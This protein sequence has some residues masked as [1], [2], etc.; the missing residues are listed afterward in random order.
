MAD[1]TGMSEANELVFLPLGGTGEIGMNLNLYGFGPPDARK[2]MMVDLGVTF[3]D[4]RTPGIDVIMADPAFIEERREDLLGIVLTHGHEDH[5]GAVAHLWPSLRCD[6]YATPFT[7]ELVKAKLIEAG[8]EQEVPLKIVELGSR[9]TLG[10]FDIELVTLTHSIPEPNALAI[11]TPLGLVMHTGDWKIDP[12]PVVGG[13][14]DIKR[15]TELGQ[16]GVRAMVCD[17]TN[18]FSPGE[19]GSEADVAKGLTELIKDMKGRVAVTT[20][21][22]NVA[23]LESVIRAAEACGRHVVLAG[24]AMHRVTTAARKT[25][26]LQNLPPIVPEDEAGYLPPENVLYL[27]TGSQGEPRAALARIAMDNHPHVTLSEGDTVIFS[28]RMIPGNDVEIYELQ[29]LLAERGIRVIT[30][31]DHFVH[32]SGHPC[33][34]ELARMYQWIKPEVAVPVHGEA[35]HLLE[36][37][38]LARE[39]QVPQAMVLKNGLMLRLAPGPAEIIDEAPNGRLYLDGDILMPS[40]DPA[41]QERRK[42]AFAGS[43]FVTLVL[44][45]QGKV[46][47]EPQVRLLG[48]PEE[49]GSGISFEERALDAIDDVLDRLPLRKRKDDAAVAELLRRAVRGAIRREWGKKAA[50]EVIVTRV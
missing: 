1:G 13:D 49:D 3:S 47:G 19:S 32:V 42:L 30:E 18:V 9:F 33:R 22:S 35:R 40:W 50:V 28:S 21:A 23:R 36:H 45:G 43:V 10:P 20:F 25:G 12:D 7:A 17:S 24:R 4:L 48:L 2:W 6:V 8:I 27:C 46:L 29:N 37:A 14:I 41:V 38:E 11:R 5:I 34:D 31:K 44:D 26:Y 39:L 16:E 15:L